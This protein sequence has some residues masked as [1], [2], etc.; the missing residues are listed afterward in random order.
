SRSAP[1]P[2][3]C[4]TPAAG[5]TSPSPWRSRAPRHAACSGSQCP[6]LSLVVPLHDLGVRLAHVLQ[7]LRGVVVVVLAPPAG[8]WQHV[9]VDAHL[10][11]GGVAVPPVPGPE[12]VEGEAPLAGL[13]VAVDRQCVPVRLGHQGPDLLDLLDRLLVD[14]RWLWG[15]HY[16]S[17]RS[18]AS[19]RRWTASSVF[20][21]PFLITA[22]C[23]QKPTLNSRGSPM[24][25]TGP[26]PAQLSSVPTGISAGGPDGEPSCSPSENVLMCPFM[27]QFA[28]SKS[29]W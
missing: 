24:T 2:A 14:D 25:L 8:Q 21:P 18:S 28:S 13:G 19:T 27:V 6:P 17:F 10:R 1:G 16:P 3:R 15:A 11:P 9:A 20:C 29:S 12:R 23:T 4:R 7:G 22:G 5:P 26:R